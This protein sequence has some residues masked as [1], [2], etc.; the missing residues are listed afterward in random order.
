MPQHNHN[1]GAKAKSVLTTDRHGWV[2]IFLPQKSAYGTARQSRDKTVFF[3]DNLLMHL[4]QK[5]AYLLAS[6][7]RG[8]AEKFSQ[9][10]MIPSDCIAKT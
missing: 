7:I 10:T 5:V 8:M 1:A 4:H 6:Q 3:D 2:W 9:H